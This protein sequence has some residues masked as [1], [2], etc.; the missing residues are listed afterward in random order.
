MTDSTP[1]ADFAPTPKLRPVH[2]Q[3]SFASSRAIGAL[4]LREMAT[5]YGRSPMGYLWAVAE[6]VGGILLLT[7][8]FS[9]GF[10]SPPLGTNFPIFY[11]TGIVPFLMYMSLSARIAGSIAYS[12][13]FLA[14][15]AVTFMDAL[16]ARIFLN[17]ITQVLVAYI[18]F[19]G[20]YFTQETRTDPQVIGIMMSLLMAIAISV[21]VGTIN[22]FLATAFPTWQLIWAILTRPMFLVSCIFFIFDNV[23][24][25]YRDWLW[26]NPLVH[27]IG[28]MRRS[29]YPSYAGDYVSFSYTF[30]VSLL[31]IVIG[32]AL[33]ARYHR[34]L[35]N[36]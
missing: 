11:A 30:G 16:I 7:A 15:P 22:C 19:S 10:A 5:T 2:R 14:Y 12:R 3:R 28:Q 36:S 33:L 9:V 18:V 29:F 17:S 1:Q 23:P 25:P 26:Y 4:I 27:V 31:L 20:I 32:L 6:P 21:G 8:I 34:D 24:I 13:H 35:L